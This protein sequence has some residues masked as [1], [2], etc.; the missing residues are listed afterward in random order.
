MIVKCKHAAFSIPLRG[1]I[2]S[3][4]LSWLHI[5]LEANDMLHIYLRA[6]KLANLVGCQTMSDVCLIRLR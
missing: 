4:H 2:C 1:N 3:S 6:N 5:P